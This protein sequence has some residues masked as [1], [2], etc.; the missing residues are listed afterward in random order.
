MNL[1]N[2]STNNLT[3]TIMKNALE[4]TKKL[5]KH[6]NLKLIFGKFA[7]L[8]I[9]MISFMIISFLLFYTIKKI[10][11]IINRRKQRKYQTEINDFMK[12]QF[13]MQKI[14]K[15]NFRVLNDDSNLSNN[16]TQ[17]NV[18]NEINKKIQ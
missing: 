8:H 11:K 18:L 3:S 5:E 16:I 7:Y 13:P 6:T 17:V 14:K 10:T 9:L 15:K 2:N 12:E 4:L 1:Y